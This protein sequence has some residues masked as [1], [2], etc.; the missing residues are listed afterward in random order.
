MDS[1]F[2]CDH[3]KSDWHNDH[4]SDINASYMDSIPNL[5]KIG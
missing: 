5:Q 2:K 1:K 4:S 3:K